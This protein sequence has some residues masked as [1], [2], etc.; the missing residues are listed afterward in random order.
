[1][2]QKYV[3]CYAQP[4]IL[5]LSRNRGG[6]FVLELIERVKVTEEGRGEVERR[7]TVPKV[8]AEPIVLLGQ[9]EPCKFEMKARG[10]GLCTPAVTSHLF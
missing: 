1:M 6:G 4:N 8:S 7:A 5:G 3:C 10:L 9:G 2:I